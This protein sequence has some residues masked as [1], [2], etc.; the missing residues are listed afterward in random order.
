MK[1]YI[2][3]PQIS[4]LQPQQLNAAAAASGVG[5][6][7]EEQAGEEQAA[8][9][10]W[11]VAGLMD[12]ALT[13]VSLRRIITSPPRPLMRAKKKRLTPEDS[14]RLFISQTP[15]APLER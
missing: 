9:A 14:L 6:A 8:A 2:K 5:E 7:G 4:R 10:R 15:V 1:L 11:R 3:N 13:Y 12:A